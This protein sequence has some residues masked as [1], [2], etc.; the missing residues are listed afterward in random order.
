MKIVKKRKVGRPEVA[1]KVKVSQVFL[2]GS[3]IRKIEKKYETVT[4]AV[5]AEV[6]PKLA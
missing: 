3:D 4:A 6:L 2:K 1:D 5:K